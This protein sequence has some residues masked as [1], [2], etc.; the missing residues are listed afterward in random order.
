MIPMLFR[1]TILIQLTLFSFSPNARKLHKL[2]SFNSTLTGS[3]NLMNF[4]DFEE[5]KYKGVG[6]GS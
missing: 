4:I 3:S 5:Q 2:S 1:C 6:L